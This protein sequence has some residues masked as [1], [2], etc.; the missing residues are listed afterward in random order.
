MARTKGQPKTG[1][2]VAGVPNK[3]TRTVRQWVFDVIQENMDKLETDLQ[4]LEPKERWQII[5]GLLPYIVS[6]RQEDSNR[7]YAFDFPD[8]DPDKDFET[9]DDDL[10]KKYL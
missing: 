9:W 3:I 6:K 7:F 4:G 5:S 1:G 10:A 8:K 2:R